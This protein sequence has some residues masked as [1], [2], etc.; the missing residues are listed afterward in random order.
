MVH[1]TDIVA[2]DALATG[3]SVNGKRPLFQ[4]IGQLAA[5]AYGLESQA[6]AEAL[7]ERE[8]LGSTGFGGG[9]AIPHAKIP[10]LDR[11]RGVVALLNPAMPF[12]AVDDAPVDIVFALLSPVDSGAE[13]LKTLARVSRYLREEGNVARLRGAQSPEALHAL[14]AGGEARDAA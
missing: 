4:K 14:L 5:S 13:H 12:D 8:K 1:F 7:L 6:V 3:L 10:G 2:L 11:M 9:V